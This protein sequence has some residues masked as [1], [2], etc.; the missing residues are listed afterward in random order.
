MKI[1]ELD[2]NTEEELNQF[3]KKEYPISDKENYGDTHPNFTPIKFTLVAKKNEEII[4]FISCVVKAG[5]TYIDCVLVS[6]DHRR[7]GI[8]RRLVSE[9]ENK[10]KELGSHKIWLETGSNWTAKKLYE[11]IGYSVRTI[12]P[13]DTAHQEYVLMDKML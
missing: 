3:K 6:F 9:A 13:N 4:G 10:A 5:I 11:K 7:G 1:F 2:N 12:L 8:G